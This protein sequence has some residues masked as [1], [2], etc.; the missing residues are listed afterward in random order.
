[1]H[2]AADSLVPCVWAS[3]DH[4]ATW[5]ILGGE[6]QQA[7]DDVDLAYAH[8]ALVESFM[9]NFHG[10]GTGNGGTSISRSTDGGRTWTSSLDVDLQAVNDRPFLIAVPG[11]PLLLS[12]T[13]P[14][15]NIF[16]VSS[17]DGGAT[18]STPALVT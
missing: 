3:A 13:A 8:G 18:W 6:T 4:G 1:S 10:L 15:G 2:A 12:F 7:G 9:T 17:L 5:A 16:V 14:P 11:G